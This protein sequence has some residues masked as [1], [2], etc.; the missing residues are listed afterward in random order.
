MAKETTTKQIYDL[1]SKKFDLV[2]RKFEN[3]FT[4]LRNIQ[5]DVK[6]LR[7]GQKQHN[8]RFDEILCA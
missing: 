4:Q 6:E 3:V 8:E 5:L 7:D 2:E 1:V